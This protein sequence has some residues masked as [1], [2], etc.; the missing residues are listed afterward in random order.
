MA[1]TLQSMT[2]FGRAERALGS[3]SVLVEIKSLNGKQLEIN[4]KIPPLLKSYEFDLRSLLS[5]HLGRGSV[6]CAIT[7][8]QN[9]TS[10]PVGL[11]AELIKSYYRALVPIADELQADTNQVLAAILRLPEVVQATTEVID[12][13]GWQLVQQTTAAALASLNEHRKSEGAALQTDIETRIATIAH[14]KSKIEALAPAR[15]QKVK[16]GI[17]KKLMEALGSD[18]IDHNRLEQELILY[19]EKMDI[20]E[21]MLR[22]GTHCD[23]FMSILCSTDDAKGK[24]LGFVLQ[25]I[26]REINTTGAK[27]YD[28]DIQRHV[29]LMKDELEKVKEQVLNLL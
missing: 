5:T 18:G 25:E 29:V 11:N 3:L 9:G 27:A 15:Q 10:K 4:L 24:K 28:A 17:G 1:N 12:A 6:E 14:T 2:G 23:Y 7:V 13:E 21:E 20:T 16:E 8:R 22:L 26:G 19:V